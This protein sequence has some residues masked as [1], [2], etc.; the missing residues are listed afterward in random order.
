MST[1]VVAADEPAMNPGVY[2]QSVQSDPAWADALV[3]A[4]NA[5]KE[6]ARQRR[7]CGAS[8]TETAES[9]EGDAA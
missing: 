9:I 4:L 2:G 7:H 8:A 6:E 5:V 1:S 3:S